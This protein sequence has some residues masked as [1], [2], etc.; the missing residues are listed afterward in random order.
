MVMDI[1]SIVLIIILTLFIVLSLLLLFM[2]VVKRVQNRRRQ[3]IEQYKEELRATVFEYL[4]RE[5]SFILEQEWKG[6]RFKAIEEL[7]SDFADVVQGDEVQE[8]ITVFAE[9]HFSEVYKRNLLHHRW[10]IRM[11]SLYAIEDFQMKGIVPFL[12]TTFQRR[13]LSQEERRQLLKILVRLQTSQW[14]ELLKESNWRLSEFMYRS[15]LGVMTEE[16]FQRMITLFEDLPEYIQ[17]PVLDMI[18]IEGKREFASTLE[19]NLTTS[20]G[21]KKIRILKAMNELGYTKILDRLEQ[22]H[23][24]ESTWEER[25][26]VSKLLGRTNQ[27]ESFSILTELLSDPNFDVRNNAAKSILAIEGGAD[28]LRQVQE[29]STDRFARDMA[30]EW[31]HKGGKVHGL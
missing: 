22:V 21:E 3:K 25:L 7:F 19:D 30:E 9:T 12:L 10:S 8:R 5:N 24:S 27:K 28:Y 18:G 16:Q 29:T 17:L 13:N 11:N 15:L 6:L 2:L 4:Y 20:K 14:E 26:M 23:T 31:L 1:L